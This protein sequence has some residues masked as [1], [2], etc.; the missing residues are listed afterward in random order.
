[1]KRNWKLKAMMVSGRIVAAD[2]ISYK[3]LNLA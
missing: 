2:K 3:V 1:M